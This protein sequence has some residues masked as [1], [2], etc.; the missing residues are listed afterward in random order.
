MLSEHDRR[1]LASIEA[2]LRGQ[3][4]DLEPFLARFRQQAARPRRIGRHTAWW[5]TLLGIALLAVALGLRNAD[6]LLLSAAIL[7][8]AAAWWTVI[9]TV[10]W[11]RHRQAREALDR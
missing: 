7:L 8:S 11:T 9:A 4:P 1:T 10:A 3:A 5:M 2:Q 6:L